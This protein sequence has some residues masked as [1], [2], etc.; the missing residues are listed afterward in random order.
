MRL[1]LLAVLAWGGGIARSL[2]LPEP[3]VALNSTTGSELL[4]RVDTLRVP[5]DE[6]ILHHVT[7][8]DGASVRPQPTS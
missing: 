5:F 4:G 3:L 7:Q 8:Q 2:P 1:R 6:A